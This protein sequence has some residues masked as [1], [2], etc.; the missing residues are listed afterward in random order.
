M[1]VRDHEKIRHLL[2]NENSALE[3]AE[4]A[5]Q[6]HLSIF[7]IPPLRDLHSLMNQEFDTPS[8]LMSCP[9][10]NISDDVNSLLVEKDN[11]FYRI[12][13]Y[14]KNFVLIQIL[15]N[16]HQTV[17]FGLQSNAHQNKQDDLYLFEGYFSVESL[18]KNL[19]QFFVFNKKDQCLEK[20]N[21][22]ISH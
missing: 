19:N 17:G 3:I 15:N 9:G 10:K 21:I 14:S 6:K 13:G 1:G 11:R 18:N 2:F 5:K 12:K 22:S 7:G 4:R 20:I 8:N 16:E